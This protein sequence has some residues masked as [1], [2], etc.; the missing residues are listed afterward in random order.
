MV[1][2]ITA[3]L[4]ELGR[5]RPPEVGDRVK[6]GKHRVLCHKGVAH[7]L[8]NTIAVGTLIH[9]KNSSTAVA[10]PNNCLSKEKQDVVDRTGYWSQ[11]ARCPCVEWETW[12][13]PKWWDG[14]CV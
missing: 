8:N 7:N 9:I 12:G 11:P 14:A 2:L 3:R 13:R 6:E 10:V 5:K 1:K 4:A